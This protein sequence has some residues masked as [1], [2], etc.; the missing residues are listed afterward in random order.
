MNIRTRFFVDTDLACVHGYPSQDH[1][2]ELCGIPADDDIKV[3]THSEVNSAA[4]NHIC[5]L[6]EP[7]FSHCHRSKS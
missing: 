6:V 3:A 2:T 7:W 1:L 4:W 5:G